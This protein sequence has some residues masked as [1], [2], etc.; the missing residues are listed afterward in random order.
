MCAVP[1]VLFQAG[2]LACVP[3]AP[4]KS[5]AHLRCISPNRM[6]SRFAPVLH[7]CIPQNCMHHP[8]PSIRVGLAAR[9][10]R[11]WPTRSPLRDLNAWRLFSPEALPHTQP[12][13]LTPITPSPPS[14][15]SRTDT[16]PRHPAQH[17]F[18]HLRRRLLTRNLW[19]WIRLSLATE[20]ASASG[21]R[22][23]TATG[24]TSG[25]GSQAG[26]IRTLAARKSKTRN[27][28]GGVAGRNIGD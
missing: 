18:W 20:S 17:L 3:F 12:A 25:P 28:G 8:N 15:Q 24:W 19:R 27:A 4:G 26:A 10:N 21:R 1:C 6:Q 5:Y 16:Q 9:L 13:L 14:S 22:P 11:R 7:L 2:H 23:A